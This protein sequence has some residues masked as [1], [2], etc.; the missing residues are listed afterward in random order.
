M[1]MRPAS[2]RHPAK[3]VSRSGPRAWAP[4]SLPALAGTVRHHGPESTKW[5]AAKPGVL[6]LDINARY[7]SHLASKALAPASGKSLPLLVAGRRS[8]ASERDTG[9]V[10]C[11]GVRAAGHDG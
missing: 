4:S 5:P 7:H 6:Q 2:Q 11:R 9:G 10:C 3:T 8:V 1:R